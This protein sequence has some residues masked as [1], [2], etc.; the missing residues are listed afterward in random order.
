MIKVFQNFFQ[1]HPRKREGEREGKKEGERE[2]KREGE[3]V[4]R[5]R[6]IVENLESVLVNSNVTYSILI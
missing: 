4:G 2:G 1:I 3:R 6:L 5:E